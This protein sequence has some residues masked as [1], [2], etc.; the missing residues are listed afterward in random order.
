VPRW[1]RR[2]LAEGNLK[3][4]LTRALI[5]GGLLRL[6]SAFFVYGPQALDDYKHG[7]WPA[8][9]FFAGLRLDLPDYRSHLLV[10]FLA[11][12]VKIASFFG[13][14]SALGQVRA[15]YL[16]LGATSLLGIYG[17]YLY[18]REF[19]SRIF[20]ALALY[21]VALF[22]LMPFM[23]TR[24]FGEAVAA[25][26]VMLAVGCLESLRRSGS[27]SFWKW[28]GAFAILALAGLFRF[29]VGLVYLAYMAVL[30]YFKNW[31]AL[32]ASLAAGLLGIFGQALI[33]FL[34][35]KGPLSTLFIYLAE[36]EGGG[37]R[38]GVSPWYNPWLFVLALSLM[39]FSFVFYKSL[40]PLWRKHWPMLVPFL[41]F[42]GAHSLAAHKEERFLYPVL[43][44]EMWTVAY[45]WSANAFNKYARKIYTPAW[46]AICLLALPVVCFI[47]T[48]EGEI[49]PP[50]LMEARYRGVIYLDYNSLFGQ[51]RF[52]FYFL[53]PP[54]ELKEVEPEE[55]NAARVDEELARNPEQNA[56]VMLTSD[57]EALI[58]LQALKGIKTMEAQCSD[59]SASGSLIDKL[60][61]SLN[62][63][64][65]QRR[66]PT[67]Y[68]VCER[69]GHG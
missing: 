32:S 20:G 2:Y 42:V 53:R 16:G 10:W 51:S 62:P 19:R 25:G 33:D 15:M 13:V 35:D 41:V 54:S 14:E 36:N 18:V 24:A 7:V 49:E 58:Q 39:P 6:F 63:K 37:A 31:R 66:R 5:A 52:K 23:S 68:L 56:L 69:G 46:I 12:F 57:P 3:T 48:Q 43:G 64:H 38:Y 65:N 21:L 22:P 17:T 28:T 55:F 9:Q 45:L 26:L 1:L 27:P 40:K 59:V 34:S 67:W 47:N 4:H 30:I 11:F 8:Y 60:L 29:H 44:L 61:Y 50:A